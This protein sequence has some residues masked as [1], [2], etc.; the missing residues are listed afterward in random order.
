MQTPV[1]PAESTQSGRPPDCPQ[2]ARLVAEQQRR[3]IHT[4]GPR[5]AHSLGWD[6]HAKGTEAR[7]HKA[8]RK[9][10]PQACWGHG[11]QG[12]QEHRGPVECTHTRRNKDIC[13]VRNALTK[14]DTPTQWDIIQP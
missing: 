1:P 13:M 10:G 14:W 4:G 3:G 2:R 9:C 5:V 12:L 11:A 8:R 6:L 7:H